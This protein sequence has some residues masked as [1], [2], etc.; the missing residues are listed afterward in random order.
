MTSITEW[1]PFG[2]GPGLWER[3]EETF[4]G[5]LSESVGLAIDGKTGTLY[6]SD[7]AGVT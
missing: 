2:E 4:G 1:P 6:A 7:A 3:P 5:G